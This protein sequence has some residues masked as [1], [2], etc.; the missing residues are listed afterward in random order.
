MEYQ[1]ACCCAWCPP[2][3]TEPPEPDDTEPVAVDPLP[4]GAPPDPEMVVVAAVAAGL[5]PP[6]PPP[7]CAKGRNAREGLCP[8]PP[9]RLL[10]VLLVL[11][12]LSLR[13]LYPAAEAGNR[14]TE[15]DMERGDQGEKARV[16][17]RSEGAMRGG[18][19]ERGE[20]GAA[21]GRRGGV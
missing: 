2:V 16:R 18:G 5:L 4:A 20:E 15:K 12:L 7:L 11:L 6:P 10:P 19:E 13:E 1:R 17:M 14:C 8:W 21:K 3:P 9:L